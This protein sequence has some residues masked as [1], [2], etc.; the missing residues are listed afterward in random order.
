MTPEKMKE[1]LDETGKADEKL[2]DVLKKVQ[3]KNSCRC[4]TKKNIEDIAEQMQINESRIYSVASF[5]SML[6]LEKTGKYLIEICRSPS[7]HISGSTDILKCFEEELGIN[8]GKTTEDGLFTLKTSSCIGAC[9]A[10]PAALVN[11]RIV[12]NLTGEDVRK[13][14]MEM[15][16]C[17]NA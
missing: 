6:S 11:N 16:K 9:D 17:K 13:M 4:I 12:G 5:Y 15:R 10:A 14:V 1:I 7:C 2:V 3:E 8:A